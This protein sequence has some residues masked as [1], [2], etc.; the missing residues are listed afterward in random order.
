MGEWENGKWGDGEMGRWGGDGHEEEGRLVNGKERTGGRDR[1]DINVAEQ[2]WRL[3]LVGSAHLPSIPP[4]CC[5]F[6]VL[7]LG[8]PHNVRKGNGESR[9]VCLRR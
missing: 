7:F 4:S 9:Q 5:R 3:G 1:G 2:A 8:A 6:L